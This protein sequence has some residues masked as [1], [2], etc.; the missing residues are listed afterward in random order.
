MSFLNEFCLT[1]YIHIIYIYIRVYIYI[2]Y[3]FASA[4]DST[5]TST[6]LWF[7]SEKTPTSFSWHR[8]MLCN[9][10]RPVSKDQ[11]RGGDIVL[12]QLGLLLLPNPPTGTEQSSGE[13]ISIQY[14]KL[15]SFY[16]DWTGKV[17]VLSQE[18]CGSEVEKIAEGN[19]CFEDAGDAQSGDKLRESN[20]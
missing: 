17:P 10:R 9:R 13:G 20:R 11:G 1:A 16:G 19:K 2:V 14:W 8:C 15:G 18:I 6:C 7:V 4:A 3:I 12:V 5:S